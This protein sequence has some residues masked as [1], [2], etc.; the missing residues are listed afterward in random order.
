MEAI[1]VIS[2]TDAKCN[3]KPIKFKRVIGDKE[4]AYTIHNIILQKT[5]MVGGRP[6]LCY[7]CM[8]LLHNSREPVRLELRYYINSCAWVLYKI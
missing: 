5:E 3:I 1:E 8:A 6:V 4:Q 7:D 2:I